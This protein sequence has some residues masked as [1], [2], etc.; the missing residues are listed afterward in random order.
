VTVN[1][2]DCR[3]NFTT[4]IAFEDSIRMDLPLNAKTLEF[5]CKGTARPRIFVRCDVTTHT[6]TLRDTDIRTHLCLHDGITTQQHGIYEFGFSIYE[7]AA[8][9]EAAFTEV[10]YELL[11]VA[12]TRSTVVITQVPKHLDDLITEMKN[13]LRTRGVR[14]KTVASADHRTTLVLQQR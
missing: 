10:M 14:Y 13:R 1:V 11:S 4:S 8:S 3:D 2:R 7:D 6:L 12:D 9:A 5:R